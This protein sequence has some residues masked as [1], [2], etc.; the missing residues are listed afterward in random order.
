MSAADNTGGLRGQVRKRPIAWLVGVF[1]VALVAGTAIGQ[2][3]S[4][5]R[6]DLE[7][8]ESANAKLQAENSAQKRRADD[9]QTRVG[10]LEKARDEAVDRADRATADARRITAK[11]KVP[12]FQGQSIEGARDREVLEDFDWRVTQSSSVSGAEPGTVISQRPKAGATLNRGGTISLVVAKK[13]PPRPKQWVTVY[14]LSGAGSKRTG[15]FRIPSDKKVRVKYTY[16]GDSND[17]LHLKTPE[18]GDDSFGDL[19]V[20]EIGPYSGSSRLYG[21]SGTYYLDIDGGSWNIEV[22]VFK[23]P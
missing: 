20:N 23:R 3:D 5:P 12:S 19:I 11:G 6:T 21:K 2:A 13:A 14:S 1:L 18:E 7:K 17:T 9:A 22:Q 15:E 10:E 8:A 4:V 16:G